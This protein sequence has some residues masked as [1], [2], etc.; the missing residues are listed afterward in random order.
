MLI[1]VGLLLL[2]FNVIINIRYAFFAIPSNPTILEL[3][4]SMF[5]QISHHKRT[6]VL[7]Q[8]SLQTTTHEHVQ[9]MLGHFQQQAMPILH[10]FFREQ[11]KAG[12]PPREYGTMMQHSAIRT[13]Y[14]ERTGPTQTDPPSP[15]KLLEKWMDHRSNSN[16]STDEMFPFM[17]T[18]IGPKLYS[19][20]VIQNRAPKS[21]TQIVPKIVHYIWFY[22]KEECNF[23]FYNFISVLSAHK[24]IK[25]EN[26][27]I[28]YDNLPCG[29]WWDRI[30]VYIPI[31]RVRRINPPKT[32][33]GQRIKVPEHRSDVARLG[34]LFEHGG[35]Y[36][37]LDMIALKSWDPLLHYNTTLGAETDYDLGNGV[38]ITVPKSQFLR[39]WGNTYRNFRD[40]LWGFNSVIMPF[41]LAQL[42]PEL[43]HVE[44]NTLYRPNWKEMGW[45][46]GEGKLWDW[47]DCYGMHLYHIKDR[48]EPNS[49]D[50]KT[51]NSTLGQIFRLVYHDTTKPIH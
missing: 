26:I 19:S 15:D 11:S 41:Y 1:V 13:I 28:W 35:I 4:R 45:L 33:F 27:I 24:Y 48:K 16:D 23:K 38:I 3:D 21:S 5:H 50:I 51:L 37:D 14:T 22:S 20:N 18:I 46:Y 42:Y 44:W 2:S 43:I 47:S 8:S 39:R 25:P 7:T 36:L 17:K 31:L 49:K 6:A 9:P 34:I 30:R 40:S 32:V 10:D 29:V 12:G